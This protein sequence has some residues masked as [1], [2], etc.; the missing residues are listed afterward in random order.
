[1]KEPKQTE[2]L[3]DSPI[4]ENIYHTFLPSFVLSKKLNF[5]KT[6]NFLLKKTNRPDLNYVNPNLVFQ[7][8]K[9][10]VGNPNISEI[11]HQLEIGLSSFKPCFMTIILST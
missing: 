6:L 10:R 8:L 5:S 4:N 2:I 9:F 1:M 3:L 7:I 11:T